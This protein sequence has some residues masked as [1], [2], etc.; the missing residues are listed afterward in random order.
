MLE[1]VNLECVRGER[2]LFRD[3]GFALAEG[4]LLEV[5]GPNGSGKTS[6]LRMVC[7][8]LAPAAGEILWR[9]QSIRKL[10][11]EYRGQLTYLGHHNAIKDDLSGVENLLFSETMAGGEATQKSARDALGRFGLKGFEDLPT[12]VLSQGQKRRVAL[13]RLAFRARCR[14][15][16][17]DEPFVALDVKAVRMVAD[18]IANQADSGGIVLLTTH[19]EV[20]VPVRRRQTL[21][22]GAA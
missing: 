7:G 11:E 15:W 10:A 18:L 20:D 14:L 22:L 1:A 4:T 12:R 19:Q 2:R 9:G 17:L 5:V 21:R 16:V 8:L 13:A 3:V 6:L